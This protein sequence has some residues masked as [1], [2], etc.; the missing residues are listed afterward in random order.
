MSIAN[1]ICNSMV[2]EQTGIIGILLAGIAAVTGALVW[3]VRGWL[4]E[5]DKHLEIYEK[6]V[7]P[8]LKKMADNREP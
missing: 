8:V 4:A 1:C 6:N 7:L 5:K 3:A 2:T